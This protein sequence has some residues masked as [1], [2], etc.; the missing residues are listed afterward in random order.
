M[1]IDIGDAVLTFLGD[2]TQLNATFDKV[3][4]DVPAKMAPA[5]AAIQQTSDSVSEMTGRMAVGANGAVELGE[6]TT[7]A[8]TKARESMY[9]A[10]GEA[11][12]L[13]EMFGIHLPRHVRTFIAEL[14]GVGVALSAAFSATAVIFIIEAIAQAIEKI[15]ELAEHSQKV[16]EAWQKVDDDTAAALAH[17]GDEILKVEAHID[18]LTGDHLGALGKTLELLDHT[19]LQ[20]LAKEITTIQKDVDAAFTE[21]KSWWDYLATFGQ[22]NAGI[23]AA[24]KDFDEITKSFQSLLKSG[25]R[26]S[27]FAALESGADTAKKKI[28]DLVSEQNVFKAAL[29]ADPDKTGPE[30]S[31]I[32]A[33]QIKIDAQKQL[34]KALDDYRKLQEQSNVLE[35]DQAKADRIQEQQKA[36]ADLDAQEKVALKQRLADIETEKNLQE[37]AFADKK[38]TADQWAA[39]QVKATLDAL[40]AEIDYDNTVIQNAKKEADAH[41]GTLQAQAAAVDIAQKLNKAYESVAAGLAKAQEQTAKLRTEFEKLI[42]VAADNEVAV[43]NDITKAFQDADAA[44]RTLGVTLVSQLGANLETTREAYARLLALFKQGV[45][46]QR[47]LDNAQKQVIKSELEYAQVTGASEQKVAALKAQLVAIIQQQIAQA[48]ATHA[49]AQEIKNYEKQLE[50]LTGKGKNS[51]KDFTTELKKDMQDGASAFALL[52]DTAKVEMDA[53]G[54]VIAD[55]F[56]AIVTGQESFGAA[57]L[58][59][60]EKMIGQMAEQWGEFFLAKGIAD[61][62]FDPPLG[63]AELAG[64]AALM[65]IGGVLSGLG[66][67]SSS[68]G[69]RSSS[70]SSG[71]SA[72]SIPASS[73]T[74]AGAQPVQTVN[75]PILS[76]GALATRP[77]FV[78]V[79]GASSGASGAAADN[80]A[81]MNEISRSIAASVQ[82][83]ATKVQVVI[84]SDTPQ[85]VKEINYLTTSGRGRLHATTSDRSIRKT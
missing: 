2:T 80:R 19:T 29:A 33:L 61:I 5:N 54:S 69:S 8:G 6:I 58:H 7:L 63:A 41:K 1:A 66:S 43:D 28:A 37:Q 27:A 40:K 60:T 23:N 52:A 47:D 24:K 10:R 74:S 51:V 68:A 4:T 30:N 9:E 72:A 25:D 75:T 3:G 35:Q 64:G 45:V 16:A 11:G 71:S 62:F 48:R 32:E 21:T 46:T 65:A 36:M 84:H 12:L 42:P 34:T 20:N 83:G 22:G 73:N 82:G 56:S 67:A 70:S 57:M 59:G 49:S 79:G 13:G 38:I 44:A 26:L 55:A 15:S 77:A 76:T 50:Q 78:V 39:A 81:F 53:M 14:P 31:Q 85:L 18:E 17:I